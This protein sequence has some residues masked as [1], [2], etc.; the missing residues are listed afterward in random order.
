MGDKRQLAKNMTSKIIAFTITVAVSFLLTPFIIKKVGTEAYGFVNL[1]N[2]FVSYAALLT[3]SLSS[4]AGRFVT[5]ELH[6]GNI[7]GANRYFSSVVVANGVFGGILLIGAVFTVIFVEK[8]TNI[9]P[10]LVFDVKV[11]YAL[12]FGNFILTTITSVFST[13]TFARNRVDLESYRNLQGQIIKVILYIF[14]FSVFKVRIWYIGVAAVICTAFIALTNIRYTKILLPEIKIK[15]KYFDF[16]AV[17]EIMAT[18]I[19][20]TVNQ[21][22]Q[23]LMTGFDLLLANWFINPVSMGLLGLSK[24][25]PFQIQMF[26]NTIAAVFTPQLTITYAKGDIKQFLKEV[27]FAVKL[28]GFISCIPIIGFMVFGRSFYGIWLSNSNTPEE[29]SLIAGLSGLV[30]LPLVLSSFINPLY[31]INT[32]TC[33]LKVPVL[34]TLGLGL[35]NLII[36]YILLKTT[37]AGLYAIAGVSSVLILMR[38]LFF[39]PLYSAHILKQ[40][41]WTFYIT[42]ARGIIMAAVTGALFMVVNRAVSINTW[43]MLILAGGIMGIIGYFLGFMTLFNKRERLRVIETLKAKLRRKAA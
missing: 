36:V 1:A 34:V 8:I 13:A 25:I 21:L 2:N 17:T 6:K 18:G 15:K 14:M 28:V 5:V 37:N 35:A 29:I 20:N 19:W 3:I 11:L 16:K 33:K 39:V 31:C 9:S 42:L 40:K 41:W 22:S 43:F 26:T 32:I 10:H 23:I 12:I 24:M 27:D 7:Q 38:V 30:L 4:M